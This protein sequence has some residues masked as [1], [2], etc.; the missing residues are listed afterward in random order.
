M[1]RRAVFAIVFGVSAAAALPGAGDDPTS[2]PSADVLAQA[3]LAAPGVPNPLNEVDRAIEDLDRQEREL[4]KEL[5]ALGHD[6]ESAH[7]RTIARGRAYVRLAKAGLLP[8]GGGFSALVDHAAKVERMK[9]ALG[10]DIESERKLAER[11]V[12]IGRSLDKIKLRRAP[13]EVQQRALAQARD[14]ILQQQDRAL[15]FERAFTSSGPGAPTAVYGA[16]AGVG[17]SDPAELARGFASM[18]GRLPF[19]IPGRAELKSARRPGTDGPGIEMRAPRGTPVR[20]VYT[21]RVAFADEYA[22]YGKTVILDHG[23]KHY[24]VSANLAD[25][26]VKVGDEVTTG[27]RIGGVGDMGSG[28]ML[29]FEI[30]VGTESVDPAEWFGI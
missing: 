1:K 16:G 25:F 26:A 10:R 22:S 3:T 6:A 9:R 11:R 23:D 17:P 24:T 30:R 14:A 20:A 2:G 4:K 5:A 19:P 28:P 21:G 15:A 13:L 8:V 29:Y 18:K 27:T 7:A 12:E